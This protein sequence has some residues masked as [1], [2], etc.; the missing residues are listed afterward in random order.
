MST[1]VRI[2]AAAGFAASALV[3]SGLNVAHATPVVTTV[4]NSLAT[5]F[6]GSFSNPNGD[7]DEVTFF[8]NKGSD[9]SGTSFFGSIGKNNTSHDVDVTPN[10]TVTIGNGNANIKGLSGQTTFSSITF[11]PVNPKAFDGILFT[12]QADDKGCTGRGCTPVSWDGIVKVVVN[13][14]DTIYFD[15]V[16]ANAA[17]DKLL[18]ESIDKIIGGKSIEINPITSVTIS[19]DNTGFFEEFKQVDF[20]LFTDPGISSVPEPSTWAMMILGFAG[21]GFMAYRRKSKPT[22]K[23]A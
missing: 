6:A 4:D 16:K 12:V 22:L 1:F 15:N 23:A 7:G 11:T 13:G 8:N 20:S 19:V 10:G 5:N 9:I 2:L 14:A 17:S 18:V 3:V 21:V